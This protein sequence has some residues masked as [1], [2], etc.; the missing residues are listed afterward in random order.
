MNKR[1]TTDITLS[2]KDVEQYLQTIK[3]R[4]NLAGVGGISIGTLV[5]K[6]LGYLISTGVLVTI[7]LGIVV[8]IKKLLGML[9]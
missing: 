1:D 9:L 6:V 4:H 2:K 3:K 5:G 8:L 7:L